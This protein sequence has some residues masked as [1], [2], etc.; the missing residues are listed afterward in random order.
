MKIYS[1]IHH[2]FLRIWYFLILHVLVLRTR[3][4]YI[5]SPKSIWEKLRNVNAVSLCWSCMHLLHHPIAS[6]SSSILATWIAGLYRSCRFAIAGFTFNN[7]QAAGTLQRCGDLLHCPSWT[8]VPFIGR[9]EGEP[10]KQ[11]WSIR[12]LPFSRHDYIRQ[13]ACLWCLFLE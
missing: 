4:P 13:N 7:G 3:E 8:V 1:I 5:L 10:H 9:T 12:R 11:Y 2:L 6:A